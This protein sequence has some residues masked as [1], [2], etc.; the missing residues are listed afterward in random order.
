M[1]KKILSTYQQNNREYND[2]MML[3]GRMSVHYVVCF[4]IDQKFHF[5]Y[6][7]SVIF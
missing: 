5:G 2:V 4:S 3:H 1:P 7:P 6:S